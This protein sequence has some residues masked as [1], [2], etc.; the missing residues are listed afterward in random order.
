VAANNNPRDRVPGT[1]SRFR[2][3]YSDTGYAFIGPAIVLVL[4]VLVGLYALGDWIGDSAGT[5][6][7][8]AAQPPAVTPDAPPKSPSNSK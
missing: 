7:G 4:V 8:P 6:T 3:P 5:R 1:R 2:F